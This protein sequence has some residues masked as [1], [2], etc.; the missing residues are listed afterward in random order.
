MIDRS[1][2]VIIKCKGKGKGFFFYIRINSYLFFVRE[3]PLYDP[4]Q[5]KASIKLGHENTKQGIN[6]IAPPDLSRLSSPR[7]RGNHAKLNRQLFFLF[8]NATPSQ[9]IVLFPV[10]PL[11]VRV[12]YLVKKMGMNNEIIDRGSLCQRKA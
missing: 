5:G 11:F 7:P 4:Y 3:K 6:N 12:D 10:A 9:K 1:I 8:F 2:D